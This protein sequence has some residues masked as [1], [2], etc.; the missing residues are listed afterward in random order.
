M[1]FKGSLEKCPE[2]VLI[3]V[4]GGAH[5]KRALQYFTP[6]V[7]KLPKID[8]QAPFTIMQVVDDMGADALE[9]GQSHLRDYLG[10]HLPYWRRKVV[11]SQDPLATIAQEAKDKDMVLIG[12]S[13]DLPILRML[14]GKFAK[15]LA[16]EAQV[17]VAVFRRASPFTSDCDIALMLS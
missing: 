2:T 12:A 9:I 17:P 7:E 11:C 10:E 14:K 4:A 6:L 16:A 5:A 3:P 8:G 15:R 13:D 1:V